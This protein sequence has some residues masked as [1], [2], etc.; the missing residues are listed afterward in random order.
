[1]CNLNSYSSH[2]Y[3][4]WTEDSTQLQCTKTTNA[5]V[6]FQLLQFFVE[7]SF[8]IT[9]SLEQLEYDVSSLPLDEC[10]VTLSLQGTNYQKRDFDR[11]SVSIYLS[12][13]GNPAHL[14][15]SHHFLVKQT[16]IKV[17]FPF[18]I[19]I[20]ASNINKICKIDHILK[21]VS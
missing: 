20:F 10:E 18:E 6:T 5:T 11:C 21:C 8:C 12:R 1:M 16:I 3:R 19:C 13:L 7:H 4:W 15:Y 17:K 9:F 14:K 2:K